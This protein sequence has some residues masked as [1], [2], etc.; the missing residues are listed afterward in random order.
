M[1]N[2]DTYQI[3]ARC[4]LLQGLAPDAR[5][6]IIAAGRLRR[7]EQGA[8][9]FHQG[10]PATLFYILV[11]GRVRLVQVTVE[12]QQVTLQYIGAG[13]GLGIIVA[14]SEMPY[15]VSAEAVEDCTALS[16][17]P[18]TTHHLMLQNPQLALNGMNLIARRFA[19]LQ[20]RYRELATERVERRVARALLRL[21]RQM[22]KR[23]DQGVLIDMPL[24]RQ[25]LAEM[26]G[27]N[28]YSV[29]RILSSWEQKGWVH[30][31]RMQVILCKAHELVMIAEDIVRNENDLKSKR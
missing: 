22:G 24:S 13:D 5:Q 25:D 15:L 2:E 10:Q 28:L 12:G 1:L 29:S 27:T 9:F 16:W 23:V 3:V 19:R 17:D 8:F 11:K 20:D 4:A 30:T 6:V 26:T 21:V 18:E 7:V 14:L 31:G